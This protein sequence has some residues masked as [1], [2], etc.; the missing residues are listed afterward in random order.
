MYF[1]GILKDEEKPRGNRGMVLLKN[2]N[3][4]MGRTRE[5]HSCFGD[6]ENKEE[7]Y[8]TSKSVN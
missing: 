7:T 8:L 3:D 1:G 4:T 6:N 2:I 5:K